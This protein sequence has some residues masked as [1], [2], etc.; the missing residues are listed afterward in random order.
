MRP[1]HDFSITQILRKINFWDSRSA[2]SSIFTHLEVE[3]LNFD[4]YDL[5]QILYAETYKKNSEPKKLQK[6]QF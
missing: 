5:F 3:A 1:F 2:Q 6:W 4:I